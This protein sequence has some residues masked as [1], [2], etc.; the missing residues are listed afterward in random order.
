MAEQQGELG[1]QKLLE[2]LNASSFP[3]AEV[4]RITQAYCFARDAHEGQKRRSGEP[5]IIHPVAVAQILAEMGMDADSICAALLHD[6]VEDTPVTSQQVKAKFGETVEQLVDGVTKIGQIPYT[7]TQE[8]Q[9]NENIRKMLLA[10]SRDIR[11]IIIKLADR[12]HNMRTLSFMPEEK[13]RFKA[14]ETLEIYAPIAHRLGIRAFK[15]ELEDL[16]RRVKE[17]QKQK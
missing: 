12:V 13:R 14:K 9:Q 8:E 16:S 15:E 17:F 4:T 10:M 5:Y 1:F 6:V 3:E 2:T 11:V 7:L